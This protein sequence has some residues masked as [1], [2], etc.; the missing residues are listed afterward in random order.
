MDVLEWRG[1]GAR[2]RAVRLRARRLTRRRARGGVKGHSAAAGLAGCSGG[3]ELR[4][5]SARVE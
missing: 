4:D 3:R 5:P 2:R 1:Q